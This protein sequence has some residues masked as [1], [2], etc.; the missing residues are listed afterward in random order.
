MSDMDGFDV[1]FKLKENPY[2]KNIPVIFLSALINTKDKVKG[3]TSE[4]SILF[5]NP[6]KMPNCLAR[7]QTHIQPNNAVTGLRNKL[8]KL[9]N[10]KSIVESEI[11]LRKKA[12]RTVRCF[13]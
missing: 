3:L 13:Y 1:C 4:L 5:Q 6:F 10:S 9:K 8:R 2:T 12:R 11:V 7:V